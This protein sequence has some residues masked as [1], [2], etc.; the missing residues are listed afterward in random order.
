MKAK[1]KPVDVFP[2]TATFICIT[3]V[4]QTES[5]ESKVSWHLLDDKEIPLTFG[6][7]FVS[8]EAYLNW[9][10]NDNVVLDLTLSKLE[11]SVL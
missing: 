6:Q 2:Q 11:L 4:E 10:I 5:N 9:G 7:S 3:A 8:K 1:I